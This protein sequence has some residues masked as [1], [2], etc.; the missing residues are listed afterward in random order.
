MSR[1]AVP[2]TRGLAAALC[3]PGRLRREK[4]TVEIMI[5]MYCR[6]HHTVVQAKTDPRPARAKGSG[7]P[8]LCP[9]CTTLQDY[10]LRRIDACRFGEHK[11]TCASCPVHCF[12]AT[13]RETIR[14][15]MRY[16]GPR[17]VWRHPYLAVRH[18][19][20]RRYALA[21]TAHRS[22]ATPRDDDRP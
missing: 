18:L 3:V 9:G 11:P 4:H 15:V 13:E 21:T 14:R 10:A 17:I 2:K 20:D 16:S 7:S 5:A 12:R 1:M 8:R 6:T 22:S 19:L